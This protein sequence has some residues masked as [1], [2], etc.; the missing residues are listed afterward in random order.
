MTDDRLDYLFGWFIQLLVCFLR[1]CL[2]DDRMH[3]WHWQD[4]RDLLVEKVSDPFPKPRSF[5]RRLVGKKDALQLFL[6]VTHGWE[7]FL[8]VVL[9]LPSG[10]NI[11]IIDRLTKLF[12]YG[13]WG[14]VSEHHRL[15]TTYSCSLCIYYLSLG[16][17]SRVVP[18]HLP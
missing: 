1:L 10:S 6:S 17:E 12:L 18:S 5:I 15:L 16:W 7:P 4:V 9:L 8:S 3:E 11:F 2:T 13:I 14:K